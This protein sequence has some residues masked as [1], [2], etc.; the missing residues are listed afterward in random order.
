MK[1]IRIDKDSSPKAWNQKNR[2]CGVDAGDINN[3]VCVISSSDYP[4]MILF[5]NK[6][7]KIYKYIFINFS[8]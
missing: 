8:K 4:I 7:R 3:K 1:A 5:I 6:I 2:A